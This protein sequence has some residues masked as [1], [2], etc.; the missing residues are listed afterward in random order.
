MMQ[1]MTCN[2]DMIHEH[3]SI[4]MSDALAQDYKSFV[5][6]PNRNGCRPPVACRASAVSLRLKS[7]RLQATWQDRNS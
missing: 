1:E 4:L 5:K 2:Y 6:P 3:S 7:T